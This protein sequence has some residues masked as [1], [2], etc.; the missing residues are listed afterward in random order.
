MLKINPELISNQATHIYDGV[1][2]KVF[3]NKINSSF[4][5]AEIME[6]P[7]KGKW[8]TVDVNLLIVIDEVDGV[9]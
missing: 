5:T 1:K 6:G 8:T 2:V 9:K 7:D 4:R 3:S